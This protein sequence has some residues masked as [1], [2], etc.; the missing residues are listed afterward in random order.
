MDQAIVRGS[1]EALPFQLVFT[2]DHRTGAAG[3]TPT[4]TISKAGGAFASPAGAIVELGAGW[5]AVAG[6]A[7]DADTAGPLLLSVD[8][9][10]TTDPCDVRFEVTAT[11]GTPPLVKDSA[12]YPLTFLLVDAT[13]HLSGKAGLTPTVVISKAGGAFATPAGTVSEI[14]RGWYRVAPNAADVDTAGPLLLHAT[15]TGADPTDDRFDVADRAT[16]TPTG[17]G[18]TT[19]DPTGQFPGPWGDLRQSTDAAFLAG[20]IHT[21]AIEVD[22]KA[23][24]QTVGQRGSTRP[25]WRPVV[26]FE[27]IPCRVVLKMARPTEGAMHPADMLSGRVLFGVA[28]PADRRHRLAYVNPDGVDR[29]LY[30][31][32]PVRDAHDM[33]HHWV[34]DVQDKPLA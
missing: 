2:S 16:A 30:L 27:E 24:G 15:A 11:S 8:A 25:D 7:A 20:L 12:A 1:P 26:G 6:N 22:G 3:I 9:T 28:I 18:P 34:V 29:H 5:Y 21:V 31:I 10:G 19:G 33:G 17:T 23:S 4:V 32:G 14:G 13:D